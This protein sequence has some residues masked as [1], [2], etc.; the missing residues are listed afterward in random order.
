MIIFIPVKPSPATLHKAIV[1]LRN[2]HNHPMHP[3]T[4][5]SAEDNVKL[6]TAVKSAG[7]TGL[8]V[9]KLRN[10]QFLVI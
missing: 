6:G 2:P 8:T 4:K 3:K 1:I 5:P 9:Q 7:L 10:G